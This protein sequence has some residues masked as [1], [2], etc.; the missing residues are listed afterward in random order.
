MVKH[1]ASKAVLNVSNGQ[2]QTN[3]L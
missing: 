3:I 1:T 2:I